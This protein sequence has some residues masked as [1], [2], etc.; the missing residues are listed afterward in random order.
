MVQSSLKKMTES[1]TGAGKEHDEPG[2]SS[3]TGRRC[4]KKDENMSKEHR[5]K[6]EGV[7]TGQIRGNWS[8]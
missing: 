6:P 5:S 3:V 4:S 7:L 8:I 1:R 2:S